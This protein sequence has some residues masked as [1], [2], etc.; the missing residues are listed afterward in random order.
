MKKS[1]VKQLA[2]LMLMLSTVSLMSGCASLIVIPSDKEVTRIL[3][4][5]ISPKDG[6]LVPDARMLEILD[7]IGEREIKTRKI[8]TE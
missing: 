8:V 1:L 6:Y 5:Q 4:G 2:G 3:K 7:A